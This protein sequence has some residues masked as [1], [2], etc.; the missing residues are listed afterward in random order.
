M[1]NIQLILIV[2]LLCG[3]SYAQNNKPSSNLDDGCGN[4]LV[5]SQGYG[6]RWGKITKIISGNAVLFEQGSETFTIT[7][8][9]IDRE[10]NKTKILEFLEK[11]ILNQNVVVIGNLRKES[12]KE[13]GGLVFTVKDRSI[14][15][16]DLINEKLLE[17]GIAKYKEFSSD[18]LIP[19][20]QPCRLQKAEERAKKAKLGIWAK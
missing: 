18:N 19:Y 20:Y 3:I 11:H 2:L 1:K 6:F 9:G 16:I 12:D 5:E 8:V 14:D 15:L 4:P 17:L 10:N 13:F 7:L